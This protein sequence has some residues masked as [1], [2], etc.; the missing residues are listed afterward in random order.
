MPDKNAHCVIPFVRS[1]CASRVRQ[2]ECLVLDIR[3]GVGEELPG[4]DEVLLDLG[5][6]TGGVQCVKFME[7]YT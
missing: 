3:K 4:A 7:L 6:S 1:S 5:L 2:N